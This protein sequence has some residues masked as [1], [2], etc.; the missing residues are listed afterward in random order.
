MWLIS[1]NRWI[2]AATRQALEMGWCLPVCFSQDQKV[3]ASD[4]FLTHYDPNLPITVA[5]DASNVGIGAVLLHRMPNGSLKAVVHASR[6]LSA[7]KKNYS[8]KPAC[9]AAKTSFH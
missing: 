6:T 2:A 9:R 7:A 4:L 3:L 8:I 1:K 5:A